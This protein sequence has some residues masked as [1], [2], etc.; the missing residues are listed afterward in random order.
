MPLSPTIWLDFIA[1]SY[2]VA[3]NYHPLSDVIEQNPAFTGSLVVDS[4]GALS[5]QNSSNPNGSAPAG[6]AFLNAAINAIMTTTGGIGVVHMTLTGT[7]VENQILGYS[8]ITAPP[9]GNYFNLNYA[10]SP[11]YSEVQYISIGGVW[12]I[13]EG[14]NAPPAQMNAA[15]ALHLSAVPKAKLSVNGSADTTQDPTGFA[16]TGNEGLYLSG[17]SFPNNDSPR[18][19]Q[20]IAFYPY[21]DIPLA[22][23]SGGSPPGPPAA[24][25]PPMIMSMPAVL[26]CVPCCH[27]ACPCIADKRKARA[28]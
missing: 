9:P 19:Y 6:T 14:V 17:L 3:G 12:N 15:F 10:P 7:E 20:L 2:Y 4:E 11:P 5:A 1:G 24:Q 25:K 27:T 22:P 26:P 28:Q 23:F 13:T 16:L 8:D 21:A 18:H